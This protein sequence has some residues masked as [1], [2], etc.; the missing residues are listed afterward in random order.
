MK[1]CTKCGIEKKISEFGKLSSSKDGLSYSCKSCRKE[2]CDKYYHNNKRKIMDKK[3]VYHKKRRTEEPLFRLQY[4]L[5]NRITTAFN[6]KNIVKGSKT[7]NMLG[8]DWFFLQKYI[9]NK[10]TEGMT[11]E[12]YGEWHIDHIKP[13]ALAKTEDELIKL[14]HYTNL[15]PLWA[16]ENIL[17]GDKYHG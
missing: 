10:F 2:V 3:K 11:W 7:E 15:Q 6:R 14:N 5:R 8:C 9:Q 13:L 16:E 4:N 1:K 12:N 17:K